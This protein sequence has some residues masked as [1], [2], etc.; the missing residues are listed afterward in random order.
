MNTKK[1]HIISLR[2][3]L[4]CA[5][6]VLLS[7]LATAQTLLTYDLGLGTLP[8]AQRFTR[9][10]NGIAPNPTVSGGV[11]HQNT[12][13]NNAAQQLW[14]NGTACAFDFS[15]GFTM[16]ANLKIISSSYNP[17]SGDGRRRGGYGFDAL[18][19][20]GRVL[21]IGITS[22]GLWLDVSWNGEPWGVT[23]F[24]PF[25]ATSG[26]NS[27]RLV[28]QGSTATLFI[29]GSAFLSTPLGPVVTPF[30]N[31]VT[32][33][34]NTEFAGSQTELA[35]FRVMGQ[36]E[37]QVQEGP[38]VQAPN[39]HIYQFVR[40]SFGNC[41]LTWD[42]A[43]V[44]AELHTFCGLR[45]HLATITSTNE[46]VFVE[47]LREEFVEAVP[48]WGD[49]HRFHTEF[50]VGGYQLRDQTTTKDGWY[51][52]NDEGPI[53][54]DNQQAS[55][56]NWVG[57]NPND[58]CD[59][60]E[61]N[62]ENYLAVGLE[63]FIGWNDEKQLSFVVGY[64]IEYEDHE[65]P[66]IPSLPNVTGQCS[67]TVTAP[68][69]TDNCAGTV[70]GTT[71]DPLFYNT[72]GTFTVH[73][74]FNDGNGNSNAANQSVIVQDTILPVITGCPANITVSDGSPVAFAATATD[75]CGL[76]NIVCKI[77]S[78]VITSP[79]VFPVGSTTVDVT[80]T[81]IHTNTAT[82][83]FTVTRTA[84]CQFT[85]FLPPIDGADATGG[86]FADPLRAFKLGSTIP[87]KFRLSCGGVPNST[88]VHTLQAIKYSS[89]TTSDP[90]I[91]ATPTDAVTTG[92]QFRVTDAASGEW[93][94]NLSTQ[95]GFSKGTWKLVATLSDGS[96]HEVWIEVKK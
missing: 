49:R 55:Y 22:G 75:N 17:D 47:N 48:E 58:C 35:L 86:S 91:D 29:N 26:F 57:A 77:G 92:N 43:K 23:P 30:R 64:V 73:W 63:G 74:T 67:A 62:Q 33:G 83:Q 15:A 28:A 42:E 25:D 93:H 9:I 54:G 10:D 52:V 65:A 96:Q 72:Q 69:A 66:V 79:C 90:A 38:Q 53:A 14:F 51:W 3:A 45:G 41:G 70:T 61:N 36:T 5:A 81:D 2:G 32:F 85:G 16:E 31:L 19:G 34:E 60:I 40:T 37:G 21:S 88:G 46:D 39:G 78:T 82:C 44:A 56:A 7:H 13:G 87:V 71:S 80:A 95:S 8:D 18:D 84:S 68:I 50:W 89:G 94:F 27:Y 4:C 24:T 20:T 76:S 59:N 11:L 12:S 1:H 6:C